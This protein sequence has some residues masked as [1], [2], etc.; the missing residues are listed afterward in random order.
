MHSSGGT[1]QGWGPFTGEVSAQRALQRSETE[2]N[3]VAAIGTEDEK[4]PDLRSAA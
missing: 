3:F 2:A 4:W 1:R